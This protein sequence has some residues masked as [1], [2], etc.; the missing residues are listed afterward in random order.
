MTMIT[1]LELDDLVAPGEYSRQPNRRHGCLR[2]RVA[3]SDF[4]HRGDGGANQASHR[5][6][7]RI[8]NAETGSVL[9]GFFDG[10]DD[11]RMRVAENGRSPGADVIDVLVSIHVPHARAFRSIDE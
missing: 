1:A 4:L 11:R 8:G 9:G 6:L 10:A 7:Q 2:A 3:H 5:Y